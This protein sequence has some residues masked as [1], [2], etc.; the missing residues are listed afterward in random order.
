MQPG[1]VAAL[2]A[3]TRHAWPALTPAGQQAW[4]APAASAVAGAARQHHPSQR[5]MPTPPPPV[6]T[7]LPATRIIDVARTEGLPR[8]AVQRPLALL[9]AGIAAT[10]AR[11]ASGLPTHHRVGGGVR[12]GQP[13]AYVARRW[14][15]GHRK[16]ALPHHRKPHPA[17][18]AHQPGPGLLNR[19]APHA[20]GF[21]VVWLFAAV[22]LAVVHAPDLAPFRSTDHEPGNHVRLPTT[23]QLPFGW[24]WRYSGVGLVHQSNGQSN[25]LSRSWNRC[26]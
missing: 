26:T 25:P 14:P 23:A 19:R 21:G 20:Q 16:H 11:S 8:P 2:S 4:Q 17:V 10:A 3:T 1:A 24:R 22:V 5:Q 12:L 6:D 9:G 15:L 18:G 13:P 7:T